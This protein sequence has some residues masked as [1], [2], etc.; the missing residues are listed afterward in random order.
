[1]T[2]KPHSM[3]TFYIVW[4]G[5]LVST[6][7]TGLTAF[8]IGVWLYLQTGAVTPLA[9]LLLFRTLPVVLL[10]PFAGALVD[11]WDRRTTLILSDAGAALSTLLLVLLFIFT[12]VPLWGLYTLVAFGSACE[13]FQRPALLA[14]ITQLVP[15]AQY[16]RA[17]G[18]TQVAQGAAEIIAPLIA[19]SLITTIGMQGILLIDFSTFLVAVT[20][21]LIVRFPMRVV[22][23]QAARTRVLFSE[24]MD[25]VRYIRRL[26]GLTMLLVFFVVVG[27][28]RGIIGAL[29]QPL[30]LSF[31]SPQS[32]GLVFTL[33]G[34]GFL[35]GSLLLSAWGGPRRRVLGLLIA[36]LGFGLFLMLIGLRP[37]VGLIALAAVGAHFCLPFVDGLNQAVWQRTVEENIQ[38][39]VFA[40]KEMATRASLMLAYI[41]TGPLADN[42]F[43]PMLM[44]DGAL[45]DSLGT[46]IGV[47][48][49]RGY[50]LTFA[51]SG[52]LVVIT[53]LVGVASTRLR[54][55][56]NA[57]VDDQMAPAH[58]HVR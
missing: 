38:G 18:I 40:L 5:Q 6:L 25:G 41:V 58:G 12:D 26:P 32:L 15:E 30:V 29:I 11:R 36:T 37:L 24:I 33:A 13:A 53:A 43:G 28:E 19:G 54:R 47:G 1:V 52:L 35:A 3:R 45:A 4:A 55:L 34:A 46:V 57:P 16:G 22:E 9:F 56:E 51:L 49:G 27:F 14:S 21:L 39:R 42:V 8:S 7:G 10:S 23:P 31:A 2:E 44:P 50:G 48:A 20:T 17:A